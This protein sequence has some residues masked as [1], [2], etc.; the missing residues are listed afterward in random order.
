MFTLPDRSTRLVAAIAVA[1]V[2]LVACNNAPQTT[3][4][5]PAGEPVV[6]AAAPVAAAV[7]APVAAIAPAPIVAPEP[8]PAAEPVVVAKP[9]PRPVVRPR[10]VVATRTV[11]MVKPPAAAVCSNCGV[12]TEIKE[13]RVAGKGTGAGAV[14]GAVAGVVVGNQIGDGNGKTLAKIAGAAGGAYLGNRIEK[15]VRAETNYEVTVKLDNGTT[16][17]ITLDSAPAQSV[18]SSVRV[19]DGGLVAK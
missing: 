18:G 8:A 9:K 11:A 6:E 7:T 12:V 10:P 4:T 3:A 2:I 15:R 16:T 17:T 19:V 13:V 5:P 14:A 1:A